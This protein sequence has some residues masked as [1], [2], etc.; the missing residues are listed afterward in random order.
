MITKFPEG[1][2]VSLQPVYLV[3]SH[4]SDRGAASVRLQ[5]TVYPKIRVRMQVTIY[6]EVELEC[7]SGKKLSA[8]QKARDRY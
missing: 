3:L 7:W 6:A 8:M 2:C 4:W 5:D 1:C